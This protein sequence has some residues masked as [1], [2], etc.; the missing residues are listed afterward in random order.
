MALLNTLYDQSVTF[1]IKVTDIFQGQ[2]R[3][4]SYLWKYMC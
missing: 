4:F 2:T 3:D 1:N